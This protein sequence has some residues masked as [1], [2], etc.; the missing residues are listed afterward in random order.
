M[1]KRELYLEKCFLNE[2]KEYLTEEDKAIRTIND[3]LDN[4]ILFIEYF[5]QM[6]TEEFNPSIIV[7]VDIIDYKSFCQTTLNLGIASINLRIASLKSYFSF[8]YL[9]EKIEKNPTE[10]IKK[11]KDGRILEPKA[12]DE[13]TF[14]TLR[15][16]YYRESNPLHICIFELLCCCGLRLSE[17]VSIQIN[18]IRMN[19][20]LDGDTPRTGELIVHGKG[21]K[22]RIIPLNKDVRIAIINWLQLRK[23]KKIDCPYLLIS[24]R[25][26]K[27][28]PN[29]IYRIIMKYHSKLDLDENYA[30]HS[31]RHY[32]CKKLLKVTDISTVAKLAGHS[33]ITTTQRYTA[34]DKKDMEDAIN[35]L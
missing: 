27:F 26:N 28:T 16:L 4:V 24:E 33:S 20:N 31:Y 25:K 32:F 7:P 23:M 21:D 5:N 2:F 18:D 11:L 22:I 19:M 17:L 34:A 9:D 8:L 14:R 6:E 3:Y 1:Q 35:K 12:F 13:K 30:V 15:R 29:G 10:K